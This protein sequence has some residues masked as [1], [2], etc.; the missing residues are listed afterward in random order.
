MTQEFNPNIPAP[1]TPAQSQ[2]LRNNFRSVFSSNAGLTVPIFF[3][4]GTPWWDE[5]IGVLR[6]ATTDSIVIGATPD[7]FL[8]VGLRPTTAER[9]SVVKT[10]GD[11]SLT[12]STFVSLL[13]LSLTMSLLAGEAA[14]FVGQFGWEND[15]SL[16]ESFFD[17][18]VNGA[19]ISG[20]TDGLIGAQIPATNLK[21]PGTVIGSFVA[22]MSDVYTVEL[23][24]RVDT[25]TTTIFA[26]GSD[27][28]ARVDTFR[29]L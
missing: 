25:G 16:A 11:I 15:T 20:V 2:P 14:Q 9:K 24:G 22:T 6:V 8:A 7:A 23:M 12:Q 3:V 10:D 1:N 5:T 18:S 19:R 13:G 17:F 28:A 29:V 4:R 27:K 26:D 21:M